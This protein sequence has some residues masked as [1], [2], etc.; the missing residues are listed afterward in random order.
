MKQKTSH[1]PAGKFKRWLIASLVIGSAAVANAQVAGDT[2]SYF[3]GENVQ[4]SGYDFLHS[5][6]DS[7]YNS[8]Q[9]R[10]NDGVIDDTGETMSA[11]SPNFFGKNRVSSV[12]SLGSFGNDVGSGVDGSI[13]QITSVTLW[14]YVDSISPNGATNTFTIYTGENS[15][16]NAVGSFTVT[17]PTSEGTFIGIDIPLSVALSGF[18]IGNGDNQT[19]IQ[20][21]NTY[22][23]TTSTA[24]FRPGFSVTTVMVIPEPAAALLCVIG[25]SVFLRRR[26][27]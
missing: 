25:T 2:Y 18:T 19:P 4:G 14:L 6:A 1:A 26:R 8:W 24:I 3:Y 9:Y 21:L 16:T 20:L 17:E 13:E 23:E 5:L 27:A 11:A 22:T 12:F 15:T 7:G 10:H